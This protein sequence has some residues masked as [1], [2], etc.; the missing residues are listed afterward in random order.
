MK[1]PSLRLGPPRYPGQ[2]PE[3]I[4]SVAALAETRGAA[5]GAGP[6]LELESLI[7]P[8]ME[9]R[10]REDPP[11]VR[12]FVTLMVAEGFRPTSVEQG[13][14]VIIRYAK[15]L[16]ERFGK[17]LEEAGWKEYTSYKVWLAHSGLA[18]GTAA[19]YLSYVSS[20]YRLRAMAHQDSEM[21]ETYMRI[22]AAG[23]GRPGA[24]RG[25]K[26]MELHIVRKLIDAAEDEDYIFLMTLLYTGGRAQFY[27]LRVDNLDFARGQL[28]VQVKYGR[29]ATIPIHPRL[30]SVLEKH[31]ATRDYASHFLFRN[32]KDTNTARG[33]RANR[34]NAWR[35]CK[36]VQRQAGIEESIHPH[37]FRKTLATFVR[38][39]GTDPQVVQ[40]LLAAARID[41]AMDDYVKLDIEE[42]R[43]RYA[44]LDPLGGYANDGGENHLAR[45]LLERLRNLGPE[46]KEHAWA[47]LVD[48]LLG[49]LGEFST[50]NA[51]SA[52]EEGSRRPTLA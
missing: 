40:A 13:R 23:V 6:G 12:E 30:A 35:I 51:A 46:G 33:Q 11:L 39:A 42:V 45:D 5:A 37:R 15:F 16:S 38:R 41:R 21:L 52:A 43:R 48:G 24:S 36:R 10:M 7:P 2:G 27:G 47:S 20:F 1:R 19:C 25:W 44:H 18:R 4:Q 17:D 50:E 28:T 29:E 32:G 22:R 34:Q 3:P 49:L 9:E 8:G 14:Q 26:P 31:L